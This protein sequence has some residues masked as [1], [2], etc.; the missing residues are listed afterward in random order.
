MFEFFVMNAHNIK[1]IIAS[2]GCDESELF[3]LENYLLKSHIRWLEFRFTQRLNLPKI[4]LQSIFVIIVLPF[5]RL[6]IVIEQISLSW[7]R[8]LRITSTKDTKKFDVTGVVASLGQSP[9]RGLIKSKR[10]RKE[11]CCKN[12]EMMYSEFE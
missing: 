10:L 7:W 12:S 2:D 5:C 3:H 6:K 1:M 11:K 4:F 9:W 8:R